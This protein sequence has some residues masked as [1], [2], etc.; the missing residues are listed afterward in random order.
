MSKKIPSRLRRVAGSLCMAALCLAAAACAVPSQPQPPDW[1]RP[2]QPTDGERWLMRLSARGVQIYECQPTQSGSRWT[3]I[4][5]D[6]EL[7]DEQGRAIGRHG[8]GPTWEAHDGSRVVGVVIAHAD[9][10][11]A[12]AIPWLLLKTR[13]AG[14]AGAFSD[15]HRIRRVNTTGGTAPPAGCDA[16]AHGARARVPYAA[17]YILYARRTLV[18][19]VGVLA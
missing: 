3:L 1:P 8:A 19:P 13:D 17:E 6:A 12:D 4:A 16:A 18:V 11:S 15:V 9:A 14:P 10:P 7:Y 2:I 5:P